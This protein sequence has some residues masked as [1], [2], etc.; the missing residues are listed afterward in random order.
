[1]SQENIIRAWKDENFRQQLSEQERALLPEHPAGSVEL[2]DEEIRDIS[3]G[4]WQA[5]K[6]VCTGNTGTCG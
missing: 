2:T 6:L 1:M 4:I 3:G 5:T